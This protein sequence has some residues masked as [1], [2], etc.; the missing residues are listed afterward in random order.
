MDCESQ[1]KIIK[2]DKN[3]IYVTYPSMILMKVTF[4]SQIK[5]N[6]AFS[7]GKEQKKSC[8]V[9]FKNSVL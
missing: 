6:L 5:M 4:D 3:G 1:H 7:L 8:L 9:V 2:Q